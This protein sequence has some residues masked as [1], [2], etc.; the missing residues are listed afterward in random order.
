MLS[1]Y[2]NIT[3]IAEWCC[4]IA[5]IFFLDKK[6]KI[7][8]LFVALLLLVLMA[9][10]TGW[11]LWSHLHRSNAWPFNILMLVSNSFF[12]WFFSTSTLLKRI[13]HILIATNLLF[14]VVGTLNLL[15][16]QGFWIYNSYSETFAD[17]ALVIISCYFYYSAVT[18]NDYIN[19]ISYDYFW[20]TTGIFFSA[21][22]SALLY[23]FS[24]LLSQ[25]Y[26]ATKLD[27]GTYINYG[28]NVT[29]YSS[30]IIA[31]IC[32]WRTTRQ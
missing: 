22:G 32:R 20:F 10:T 16:F 27:I 5:A 21:L 31:F 3:V 2:L 24:Y 26:I 17:V 23:Q 8:Q 30:L 29:L 6:T 12:I 14:V 7:W 9:E 13:R 19:L 1:R 15:F 18:S 28:L 11:Y 4:F 25:F